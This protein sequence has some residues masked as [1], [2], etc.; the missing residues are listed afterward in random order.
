M[1]NPYGHEDSNDYS[2]ETAT[3]P[4]LREDQRSANRRQRVGSTHRKINSCGDNNDGHP[5]GHDGKKTRVFGDL[6]KGPR[7]KELVDR[8]KGRNL[9]SIR[10]SLEYSFRLTFRIVLKLWQ[11][12]RSAKN[13]Q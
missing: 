11:L 10:I 4:V 1:P 7:I 13:G 8:H 2:A 9:L 6:D 5:D 12:N 3:R